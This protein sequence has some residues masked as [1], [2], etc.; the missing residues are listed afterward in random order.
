LYDEFWAHAHEEIPFEDT[1]FTDKSETDRDV[2]RSERM[3][4]LLSEYHDIHETF[5][6]AKERK[7]ELKREI[8]SNLDG[9]KKIEGENHY[10][11]IKNYSNSTHLYVREN[12]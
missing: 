6:T 9:E 3:S 12:S 1:P 5:K 2:Y 10:A 7:K 11:N 4:A 8:L